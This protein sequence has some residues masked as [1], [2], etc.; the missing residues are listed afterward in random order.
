MLGTAVGATVGVTSLVL[1]GLAVWANYDAIWFTWWLGDATGALIIA[2]VLILWAIHSRVGWSRGQAL[3]AS[4]L[5]L[6]LIFL[7]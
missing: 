4:L 7:A 1:N 6:S 5:L 2:P 3:E